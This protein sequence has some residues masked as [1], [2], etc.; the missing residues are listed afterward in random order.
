MSLSKKLLLHD[1]IRIC[2]Q[3]SKNLRFSIYVLFVFMLLVAVI[4]VLSIF[5]LS[6]IAMSVA[7]PERL[8]NNSITQHILT[9]CPYIQYLC[10]DS[11]YFTLF[12]SFSVVCLIFIKNTLTAVQNWR[13]SRTGEDMATF[14]GNNIMH[15]FLHSPYI[16][17]ISGDSSQIW[18]ALGERHRLK[19]FMMQTLNA[20]TYAITFLVLV[21]ALVCVTPGPI[22]LCLVVIGAVAFAVYRTMKSDIDR[23][24]QIALRAMASET[25]ATQNAM[26]GIREVLIYRQ[27]PIFQQK[28]QESCQAGIRA[29]SFLNIAPPIPTWILEVFGFAAIPCTIWLMILTQDADMAA[30]AKVVTLVMLMAWRIL[31]LLNRTLGSLV[32]V[33][34][35]RAGAMHCLEKLEAISNQYIDAVP[36]PAPDFHFKSEIRLENVL[37]SYPRAKSRALEAFSC[38]IAKGQQVG[39]IGKSGSGKSTLAGIISGLLQ[40]GQGR[41][42]IDERELTP[43]ELSAYRLKIGYVPQTP[44]LM[45]GSIAENVAFSQ[46]GKPYDADRVLQACRMAALDIVE[47][48]PR[49]IR[50]PLGENGAGLSGGQ[51]QRVSIARALYAKPEIL[52]LD[53]S[54]SALDQQT[55]AAIMQTIN[56]LK[57]HLTIIIIAHRLTTIEQCDHLLWLQNGRLYKQGPTLEILSEYTKSL[58]HAK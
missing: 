39:F 17:H 13:C 5:S 36:E 41:F 20:Y 35:N 7:S 10:S 38:T 3:L 27:Q 24:G 22:L 40:P 51:A 47:T 37:F 44:Y 14:V 26:R 30:I 54:T 31:P 29:R 25:Q 16:W 1:L 57:H 23:S 6:L 8:I 21:T 46:W 33:R 15:H 9:L 28:F 58:Q 11:R 45:A 43:E 53:E 52:I 4:E 18:I 49:G 42:L 56:S 50:Y 12:L 2:K 32:S 19:Q 48:D 34:S 55:E